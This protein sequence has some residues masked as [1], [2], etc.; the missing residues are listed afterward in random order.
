MGTQLSQLVQ[1]NVRIPHPPVR[2]AVYERFLELFAGFPA[3]SP[4]FAPFVTPA[5]ANPAFRLLGYVLENLTGIPYN[6]Y[7]VENIMQPLNLSSTDLTANK[8][9]ESLG[10]LVT[11]DTWWETD[12]GDDIA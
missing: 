3:R 7:V 6:E 4:T 8:P 9:A 5:Y 1:G 2:P 10:A 12:L 11:G